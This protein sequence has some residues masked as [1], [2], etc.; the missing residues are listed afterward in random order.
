MTFSEALRGYLGSGARSE[1]SPE[2][3]TVPALLGRRPFAGCA[4]IAGELCRCQPGCDLDAALGTSCLGLSDAQV[5][6]IGERVF[7]P[8]DC[9]FVSA[10]P[11]IVRGCR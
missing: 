11:S 6:C 4:G 2:C 9:G 7:S 5:A 10:L 3:D 1:L 8:G